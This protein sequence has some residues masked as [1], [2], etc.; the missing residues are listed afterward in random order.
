MKFGFVGAGKVGQAF[1][2][3][4]T[5][6]GHQVVGY[7]SKTYAH[8]EDAAIAV[9]GKAYDTLEALSKDAEIIA[10]TVTDQMIEAVSR[11]LCSL[12]TTGKVRF[13]I[14]MSG[15]LSARVL[16]RRDD[17]HYASIHPMQSFANVEEALLQ[18]PSTVFGI[19]GDAKT[20][21][22]FETLLKTMG[23]EV[24]QLTEAQKVNYHL[25][26]VIVSNYMVTLM[27]FGLSQMKAIGIEE[28]TGIK[29][30]LPLIR[31]T[32]T[33][34]ETFGPEKALTGPI[35]RGDYKTVK[36]HLQ[37]MDH[38][39]KALY[40]HLGLATLEIALAKEMD[41]ENVLALRRLLEEE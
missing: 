38:G 32:L 27:H 8:A 30:L 18:M 14:H 17:V 37:A 19:E 11:E 25:A 23:N 3:Y 41:T 40:R 7:Y 9:Q 26:A 21:S 12:N 16:A 22:V 13:V 31:G 24:I 10:L 15:A 33:N 39:A 28:N 34:I 1:G 20:I 35:A 5:Q 4:L 2:R 36:A 6:K 29:A